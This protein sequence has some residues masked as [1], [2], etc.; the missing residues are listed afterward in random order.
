[1]HL[2]CLLPCLA[3]FALQAG[4]DDL[5]RIKDKGEVIIGVRD[6][7]P[8][9]GF[10]DK[11]TGT[12]TGY[13]IEIAQQIAQSLGL[14]P[15][16]K[17]VDPADRIPA[18]KEGRIDLIVAS[19]SKN[20]ERE[21]EVGFSLGYYVSTQKLVVKKN[22][23]SSLQQLDKMSVC[24]AKGTT[25]PGYLKELSKGVSITELP[26]YA[27]AF[28]ALGAGRCQAVA[29]A[30]EALWGN[31]TKLPGRQAYEVANV[32]LASEALAVGLRKGEIRLQ[33]A[34]NAALVTLEM[35]G[36]AQHIYDNWFGSR[37]P[38]PRDRSF[39]IQY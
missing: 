4:A 39:K 24:A 14:K 34:I 3:L 35:S 28:S 26:D 1:M 21:K 25:T 29:G 9:F 23:F 8:P 6:S 11:K 10:Y 20:R 16:F 15:V 32:P 17:T 18:L 19:F 37:S 38:Q 36:A 27:E 22:S 30:E 2:R 5:D 7:S 12:V 33:K 31:L 13:D